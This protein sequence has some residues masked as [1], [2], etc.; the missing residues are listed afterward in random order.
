M[1]NILNK[2]I[3]TCEQNLNKIKIISLLTVIIL[4][5]IKYLIVF[6]IQI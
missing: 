2:L 5:I 4:A 3:W 6:N 1:I